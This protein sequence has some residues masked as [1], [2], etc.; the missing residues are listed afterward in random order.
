M[1]RAC[2]FGRLTLL[3]MVS[4][5]LL[6]AGRGSADVVELLSG[7]KV[8]GEIVEK[9]EQSVTMRVVIGG[10]AYT[11]TYAM[12]RVHAITADGQ[13]TVVNPKAGE[14]DS[15]PDATG[16]SRSARP[17]SGESASSAKR[18]RTRA[19]VEALVNEVGRTRPD[20]WDSTP[21]NYPKTLD[22]SWPEP[23]PKGWDNQRNINQYLWDIIN[24]N[25]SK[26]REGVRFMYFLG[27]VHKDNPD[28]V[29]RVMTELG[30]MYQDLLQDYARAAFWWRRA[31]VGEPGDDSYFGVKLAECYWKLG[32][33]EMAM[34]VLSRARLQFATIKLLA[35]MGETR[36]ALQIA[37]ANAR[38]PAADVALIYAGD[39]CRVSGDHGRAMQYYERILQ[40]PATGQAKGRIERNQNRA[41]ANIEA[42]KLFDTLDIR[43]VPD[44]TYRASSLGY[45]APVHVEVVVRQGRIESVRVTEHRE[46]QFYSALT[47]TTRKIVEKQ[48]VKGIDATSSATITSEAIINATAKALAG[49][50]R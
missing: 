45:E 42:I 32:S 17:G 11:R 31:G 47:D 15:R 5:V 18:G 12:E 49:G 28:K 16:P 39:A 24:H 48:S 25:P 26:Y 44:G 13:R 14:E 20:W 37:D 46:K 9:D 33:K 3:W 36:R 23:P 21:L 2:H 6:P 40:L 29:Y 22:L 8:E 7:S 34:E 43:R 30:R 41:R 19:E 27:T 4:L 10:R 50:M 1:R 35:D 38:G